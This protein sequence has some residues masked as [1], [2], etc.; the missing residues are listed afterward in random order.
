MRSIR[1]ARAGAALFFSVLLTQSCAQEPGEPQSEP[2]PVLPPPGFNVE[3]PSMSIHIGRESLFVARYTSWPYDSVT[4]W[5]IAP[6]SVATVNS[7]GGVRAIRAGSAQLSA[8]PRGAPQF[9]LTRTVVVI[10]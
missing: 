6:Q 5:E 4:V 9:R 8:Y 2:P 10:P 7:D 3:P 1:R